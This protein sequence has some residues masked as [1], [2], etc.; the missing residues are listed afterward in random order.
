[1]S[2]SVGKWS[3]GLCNRL[4]IIIRRY[5]YYMRT[6]ACV[7]VSFITFYHSY[8]SILYYCMHVCIFCVLLFNFVKYE[9]LLLCMFRSGYSVSF[10]CSVYILC[11]NVY[12]TNSIGSQS[13]FS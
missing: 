6:A 13:R 1:V 5:M 7:A 10:C 2:T 8:F 11:V 3:K 4:S 9:F 12:C